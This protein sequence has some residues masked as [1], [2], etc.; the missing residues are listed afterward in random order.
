[1][2]KEDINNL[3]R[4]IRSN[5]I[6]AVTDLP[7]KKDL[8][9]DGFSGEFHQTFKKQLTPTSSNYY[10]KQKRKEHCQT[11]SVKAG[12]YYPDTKSR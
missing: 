1:L 10:T 9:P 4:P 7:T 8:G 5:E 2:N 3:N 12:Q 6:E 11:H